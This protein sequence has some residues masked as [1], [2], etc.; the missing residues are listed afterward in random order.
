MSPKRT[1]S[2][3]QYEQCEIDSAL[4]HHIQ[5]VLQKKNNEKD[6]FDNREEAGMFIENKYEPRELFETIT[7]SFSEKTCSDCVKFNN[8]NDNDR[9]NENFSQL[10]TCT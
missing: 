6:K 10:E 4:K 2:P 3:N 1:M 5:R 9:R 7:E 8:H